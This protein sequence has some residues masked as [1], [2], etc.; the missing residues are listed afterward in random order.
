MGYWEDRTLASVWEAYCRQYANRIAVIDGDEHA[1]YAELDA[2][3][4]NLALNLL[5]LGIKP[6]DRLVVQLPNR[7]PFVYLY[8]ALQKIGA[9][10]VMAL[11]AH[12]YLE[13]SQF[14][15]IS[16][17]IGACEL[18]YQGATDEEIAVCA[19]DLDIPEEDE[20]SF[21]VA[22]ALG[23]APPAAIRR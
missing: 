7:I 23:S 11:P 15:Q 14:V 10:P 9:I 6:R 16:G 20:E 5:D 18:C 8:L 12:R 2:R 17:A 1:T 21:T 13:I 22:S 4:T 19:V 3:A